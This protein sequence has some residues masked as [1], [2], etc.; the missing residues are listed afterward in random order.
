MCFWGGAET[1]ANMK[2]H[3]W[4]NPKLEW[5]GFQ[6]VG[7]WLDHKVWDLPLTEKSVNGGVPVTVG[8][9]YQRLEGKKLTKESRSFG[10]ID[11]EIETDGMKLVLTGLDFNRR[12]LE[13]MLSFRA[14]GINPFNVVLFYYDKDSCRE[15]PQHCFS[16]FVVHDGKIVRER[17]SFFDHSN[18]GFD[19][20]MFAKY[21]HSTRIWFDE[22]EWD[23]AQTKF[24]YRKFYSETRTGQL[25]SLRPDNPVLFF[26]EDRS[27]PD[28]MGALG[29][30][31]RSVNTV[32][33]LLWVL[34]ILTI[35]SFIL[36]WR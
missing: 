21:D 1:S 28:I 17:L 30:I 33:L 27:A 6:P 14:D 29:V 16:F 25:M 36:R 2:Q 18:S 34:V 9:V 26:Y 8:S 13:A 20:S 3:L 35:I 12:L 32:R 11:T 5:D 19:P 15:D 7:Y 4:S 10:G 22:P 31:A 24:W 23:V